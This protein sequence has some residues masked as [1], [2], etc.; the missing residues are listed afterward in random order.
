MDIKSSIKMMGVSSQFGIDSKKFLQ[1][2]KLFNSRKTNILGFHFYSASNVI[3][4]KDLLKMFF[5]CIDLSLKMEKLLKIK[6]K[7]LNLG[8]DLLHRMEEKVKEKITQI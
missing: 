8:V 5:N 1:N 7:L 4:N 3:S 6:I 2:Y